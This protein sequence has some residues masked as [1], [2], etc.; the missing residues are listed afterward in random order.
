MIRFRRTKLDHAWSAS[1]TARLKPQRPFSWLAFRVRSSNRCRALQLLDGDLAVVFAG[2][3]ACHQ[4]LEAVAQRSP[5]QELAVEL[6][7][8][9]EPRIGRGT[10]AALAF[11]SLGPPRRRPRPPCPSPSWPF[12]LLSLGGLL[13]QP[14]SPLGGVLGLAFCL[15]LSASLL[16]MNSIL[17]LATR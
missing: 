13:L 10:R 7:D 9:L 4:R 14:G 3:P 6:L 16:A 15:S 11:S 12:L 17:I 8:V 1:P 5:G 2:C